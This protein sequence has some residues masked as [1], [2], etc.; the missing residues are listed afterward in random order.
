MQIADCRLQIADADLADDEFVQ[1]LEVTLADQQPGLLKLSG[2]FQEYGKDFEA[3]LERV[4]QVGK[5]IEAII[6]S[7]NLHV[8]LCY[9]HGMASS[10]VNA[11]EEYPDALQFPDW[12]A[13]LELKAVIAEGVPNVTQLPITVG[14]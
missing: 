3:E 5:N 2:K 12:Q 14:N 7:P 13:I 9:A 11:F 8:A 10:L 1:I 6:D 4:I